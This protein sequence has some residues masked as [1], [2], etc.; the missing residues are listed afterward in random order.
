MSSNKLTINKSYKFVFNIRKKLRN[1]KLVDGDFI[2][3]V[4]NYKSI[5]FF[6]KLTSYIYYNFISLWLDT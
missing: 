5:F 3:Y 2:F 1:K 4:L 6:A